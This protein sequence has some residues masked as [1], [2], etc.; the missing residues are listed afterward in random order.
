MKPAQKLHDAGRSIWL[1]NIT[2]ELFA[3][4]EV[5][6]PRIELGHAVRN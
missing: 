3:C 4:L 6:P 1:D 5:P 2:R